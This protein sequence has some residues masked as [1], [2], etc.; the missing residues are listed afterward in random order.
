MTTAAGCGWTAASNVNWVTVTAGANGSGNGTVSFSAP[1]HSGPARSGTLT[2]A[3]LTFTVTQG[4][5]CAYTVSPAQANV[6]AGGGGATFTVDTAGGCRWTASANAS[7]LSVPAGAGGTGSG[8]VQV[9]AAANAGAA[10]SGTATIAGRNV[11]INQASG[12]S[13]SLAPT[14]QAAAA[15]GGPASVAVTAPGGCAWTAASGVPWITITSGASGSGG[16]TVQYM[17]DANTGAARSGVLTIAG[18]TFTVTQASGCSYSIAPPAQTMPAAGGANSVA[19]TAPAS[20]GWTAASNV[21]WGH[22]TAGMSGTGNGTVQYTADANTGGPA[23]SGTFTIAGQT[24]T[25]SQDADCSFTVAPD[26]F[27]R[28]SAGSAEFVDVTAPGGCAWTAAS[29]VPWATITGAASGAGSGRVDFALAANTGPARSGTLTVATRT[30]TINQ[31]SGCTY[32]LGSTSYTSPA[33]GGPSSVT[34]AAGAGCAWT[35]VSQVPWI[36]VMAGASGSGDG[37][38]QFTVDPNGTG[39]PRSGAITI[40]GQTFTVDEQ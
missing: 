10:R 4:E 37:S 23:R 7:W 16:G 15:G 2:I 17:V 24:F 18:Q 5:S 40:A 8:T 27:A 25:L 3:G 39:A 38:V 33:T 12:C 28:P 35:A 14:S 19:V 26:T 13:Y 29:N 20:C 11:T 1:A 36:T 6:G 32:T 34:V 31:D 21:P 30:V 9:T 22:L